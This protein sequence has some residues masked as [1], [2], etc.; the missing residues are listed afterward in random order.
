MPQRCLEQLRVALGDGIEA[1]LQHLEDRSML[2]RHP[3]HLGAQHRGQRQRDESRNHHGPGDRDSE[4]AQ[5]PSRRAAQEPER[6]KH[7]H[8]RDRGRNHG[9][10]DLL[11]PLTAACSGCSCSSSWCRY[12]FSSTMMASS[13]TMPMAMVSASNV[14][15]LMEK[16]RKYMIANTDTIDAGIA[17]PGITVARRFRKNTKMISTTRI[18]AIRS[19]RRASL[20]ECVT[21]TEPSNAVSSFT[22]GGSVCWMPGMASR[23]R[24]A[25]S[26]RFAFDC[27]TTPMATAG[28]PL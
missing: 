23:M 3:Q 13:T 19:V 24:C 11:V 21:N 25:T 2:V 9:E 17:S 12:A 20:I 16:P 5:Q 15:L 6:R 1:P 22:P 4:L 8:Q 7:G 27:R 18:A 26:M 10:A 28:F 14:K